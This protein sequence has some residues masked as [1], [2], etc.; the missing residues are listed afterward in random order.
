MIL[1]P[2]QFS[3]DLSFSCFI[4]SFFVIMKDVQNTAPV[5]LFNG[6]VLTGFTTMEHCAVLVEEGLVSDVFS[7]KR[8]DQHHFQPGTVAINV[9][10]AYIAPGFIDTHIH[11][12]GGYGTEDAGADPGG[13]RAATDG[14]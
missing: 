12:T 13:G 5:C 4:L 6:T 10:G 9:D 8:F 14:G 7:Q 3:P 11:G 1:E 2:A